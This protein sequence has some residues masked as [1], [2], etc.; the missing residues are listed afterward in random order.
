MR[1]REQKDADLREWLKSREKMNHES[2]DA[3]VLG[4]GLAIVLL[5][6]V[7]NYIVQT[8]ILN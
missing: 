7:V 5:S 2:R 6:G 3:I 1:T 8:F 4:I